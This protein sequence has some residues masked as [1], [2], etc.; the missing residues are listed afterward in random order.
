VTLNKP[1]TETPMLEQSNTGQDTK[2]TVTVIGTKL[3]YDG[4]IK[5]MGLAGCVE[6]IGEVRNSLSVSV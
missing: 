2:S 1:E 3:Y 6:C 5:T 4:K